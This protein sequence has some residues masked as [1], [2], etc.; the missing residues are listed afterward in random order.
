MA[1]AA[2]AKRI[3]APGPV[4][5]ATRRSA[6]R[7][8]YLAAATAAFVALPPGHWPNVTTSSGLK[9]VCIGYRSSPTRPTLSTSKAVT[10]AHLPSGDVTVEAVL[11]PC[12]SAVKSMFL[13]SYVFHYRQ[14]V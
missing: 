3:T 2:F 13:H 14:P 9:A 10:F 12:Y 11:R 8:A 6:A 1:P 5:P 7:A 4:P